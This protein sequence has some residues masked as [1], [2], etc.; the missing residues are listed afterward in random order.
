[1]TFSLNEAEKF[2]CIA[3]ANVGLEPELLE[4]VPLDLGDDVWVLDRP[5][6]DFPAYWREWIGSVLP[7][8]I[9]DRSSLVSD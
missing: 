5:H 7:H 3:F 1:M 8:L 2:A 9:L 6:F 4:Q